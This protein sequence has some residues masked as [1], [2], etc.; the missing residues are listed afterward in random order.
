MLVDT[1]THLFHHQYDDDRAEVVNRAIEAGVGKMLLP[2]IDTSTID[3][4]HRLAQ[5]FPDQCYPMMGLHP[6]SVKSGVRDQLDKLERL[7]R[8]NHYVAVGETGLD[9]YWDTTYKKEQI[10][11]L[12][13][14][15]EWAKLFKLPIVLHTRD[16]F[17]DV[18]STIAAN[19]G[20]DL[21]GVFHCFSGDYSDAKKVMELGG[22]AM[23]IGG[24]Y[25][26]KNSDLSQQLKEVPLKYLVLETDSPFLAPHP[27]RGKRNE[28]AYVKIIAQKLADDRGVE[29]DEIA[30]STTQNAKALFNK[31]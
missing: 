28:S 11:S 30:D 18:Y 15:I 1:H 7:L 4:M 31:L 23:G 5:A 3:E 29:F 9:Y 27:W 17:D 26:F 6:C 10:E 24:V 2:N 20:D 25:T 14:H 21:K 12:E 19:N 8:G 16:S 22:F 13:Q